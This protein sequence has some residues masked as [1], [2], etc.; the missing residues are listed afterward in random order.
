MKLTVKGATPGG[1]GPLRSPSPWPLTHIPVP[2]PTLVLHKQHHSRLASWHI[3]RTEDDMGSMG[4]VWM[5]RTC[6][7]CGED[8]RRAV[9]GPDDVQDVKEGVT[10]GTC[11]ECWREHMVGM[12]S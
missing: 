10:A 8:Y 9:A 4:V 6:M 3:D 12:W 11:D 2:S 1:R 5:A 7:D